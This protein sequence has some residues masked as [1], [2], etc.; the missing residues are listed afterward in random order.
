M[1]SFCI[2]PFIH[3]AG[4]TTGSY[5][6]CCASPDSNIL[7]G[8]KMGKDKIEDVWNT[9]FY[10]N[11]RLKMLNGKKVDACSVCYKQEE[12]GNFSKRLMHND[13]WS[14]RL[15]ENHID[16][17]KKDAQQ[18]NGELKHKPVYLDLRLGNICNL[19]C[20]MCNSMTSTS[21]LKEWKEIKE[22]Y[23]SSIEFPEQNKHLH[24]SKYIS[25][26]YESQEFWDNLTQNTKFVKKIYMTGGEPL[27]IKNNLKLLEKLIE[28]GETDKEVLINTNVTLLNEDFLNTFEKFEKPVISLSIDG[29][30]KVNDYIRYPSKWIDISNNIK[31]ALTKNINIDITFT[32]SA[33]N[34]FNIIPFLEWVSK[35]E[36]IQYVEWNFVEDL[37]FLNIDIIPLVERIK[38]I[39]K[40]KRVINKDNTIHN[41]LKSTFQYMT[42]SDKSS[43]LQKSFINYTK[44]LD[45]KREMNL[46]DYI[47]EFNYLRKDY[48]SHE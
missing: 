19:K 16:S 46:F 43:S 41:S 7:P 13:G 32:V 1:N 42:S 3:I 37:R 17:L 33:Y 23:P 5:R 27:L 14:K 30:G 44:L 29:I 31:K 26:W 2:L 22:E 48:Y 4:K 11:V 15:G 36:K 38:Y 39:N 45:E 8:F 28:N 21:F 25:N 6:L 20:R 47:S 9:E 10:K 24:D 34:F 35:E 18:N 40:I 12:K